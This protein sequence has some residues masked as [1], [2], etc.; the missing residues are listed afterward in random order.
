[1]FNLK[2]SGIALLAVVMMV[3]P[4]E[5]AKIKKRTH[6]HIHHT[7]S[8]CI[9]TN[10]N[11]NQ[12]K[13]N[14][15]KVVAQNNDVSA[16]T[17]RLFSFGG[18]YGDARKF[19]GLSER[20]DR[21]QIRNVTNVD[22]VR[23]PWCAAFING[24]LERNGYKKSNSNMASSF[25]RY[26]TRVSS[27]QPGDIVVIGKRGRVTHVGIFSHYEYRGNKKYVA[28]LGG[29]QSNRIQISSYPA[30]RIISIRRAS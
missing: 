6:Q 2:I 27:P 25:L 17:P 13:N 12:S 26:G 24:I 14:G 1:M 3:T 15:R 10:F 18:I 5:A 23:T 11:C 16:T 4:A 30:S 22:P 28:L 7:H 9:G 21:R 8:T 20:K 19:I 29:N